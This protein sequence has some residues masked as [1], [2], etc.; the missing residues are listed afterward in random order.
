MQKFFGFTSR[1]SGVPFIAKRV[2]AGESYGLNNC[3]VADQPMIEFYDCRYP[4][5][6]C[7]QFVARYLVDTIEDSNYTDGLCLDGGVA[8]WVIDCKNMAAVRA[9]LCY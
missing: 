4:H 2:N 1:V 7:G 3:L 8:D 9:R 6:E 5:D